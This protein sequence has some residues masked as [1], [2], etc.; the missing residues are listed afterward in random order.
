MAKLSAGVVEL[1][2][3]KCLF[4]K[5]DKRNQRVEVEGVMNTYAL[6]RGRLSKHETQII[7]LLGELPGQFHAAYGGGWSFLN[8]CMDRNGNQWTGMHRSVELLVVLGL[9]VRKVE[10]VLPRE[11]WSDFPGNMPYFVVKQ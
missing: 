6:H 2:F 1:L 7:E 5:G 4:G 8:A 9:G 3:R 10:F 11:Q